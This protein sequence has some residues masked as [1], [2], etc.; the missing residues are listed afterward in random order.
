MCKHSRHETQRFILAQPVAIKSQRNMQIW[1]RDLSI[2]PPVPG[3]DQIKWTSLWKSRSYPKTKKKSLEKHLELQDIR[4][5]QMSHKTTINP[6]LKIE[7]IRHN[8]GSDHQR[9][10]TRQLFR[11]VNEHKAYAGDLVK[12]HC[13]EGK[14]CSQNNHNLCMR[15]K[16]GLHGR[17]VRIKPLLEKWKEM[18]FGV[19]QKAWW[20]L[21]KNLVHWGQNR[22]FKLWYKAL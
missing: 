4:I 21:R 1:S 9:S 11:E 14:S 18:S 19:C 5:P 2:N 16:G 22:T 12:R 20:S 13:S 7:R 8:Q 3:R 17:V 15:H 6:L 10:V